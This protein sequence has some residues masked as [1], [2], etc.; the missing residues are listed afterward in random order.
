MESEAMEETF[1]HVHTHKHEE[2]EWK[3]RKIEHPEL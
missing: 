2:C 1:Q 3:E